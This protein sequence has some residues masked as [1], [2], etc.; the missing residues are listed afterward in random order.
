MMIDENASRAELLEEIAALRANIKA[1]ETEHRHRQLFEDAPHAIVI[2]DQDATILH[3]N[4]AGARSM[5]QTVDECIGNSL[6]DLTPDETFRRTLHH[7][8]QV[9]KTGNPLLVE[10]ELPMPEGNHWFLSIFQP[11]QTQDE[12]AVQVCHL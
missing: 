6:S 11:L 4:S 3:I 9:L 7:I 8:Q 2:Y 5:G 1:Y 10:D 12:Q